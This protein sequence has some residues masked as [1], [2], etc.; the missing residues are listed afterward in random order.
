M[1]TL[2]KN[3]KLDNRQKRIKFTKKVVK[4][5]GVLTKKEKSNFIQAYINRQ[6]FIE[7]FIQ[8][9]EEIRIANINK[10]NETVENGV[11]NIQQLFSDEY[12]NKYVNSLIPIRFNRMPALKQK[13]EGD[14][15]ITTGLLSNKQ[16]KK[17]IV[18]YISPLSVIF[19]NV[20]KKYYERLLE[21]F[22]RAGGNINLTSSA[23][24][25]R[26]TALSNEII[27]NDGY[28]IYLLFKNNVDTLNLSREDSEKMVEIM[29]GFDINTINFNDEVAESIEEPKYEQIEQLQEQDEEEE[30]PEVI[31][32]EIPVINEEDEKEIIENA[33]AIEVLV[34]LPVSE[35]KK[36]ML[37][38][39]TFNLNEYEADKVPTYWLPIFGNE[40]QML[41]LKNRIMSV[42][43]QDDLLKSLSKM[44]WISCDIVERLFPSYFVNLL[45]HEQVK[46]PD[47]KINQRSIVNDD[48]N[49]YMMLCLFLILL[50]IIS[51]KMEGQDYNFI[52]K[53]GKAIQLVLSQIA[54]AEKYV[55]DDIDIL[56][57][58]QNGIAYDRESVIMLGRNL[59]YLLKWFVSF[60]T[61]ST[62]TPLNLSIKDANLTNLTDNVIKL[63]LFKITGPK[64]LIDIGIHDI[65][66]NVLIY[67]EN[68]QDFIF[69]I[70]ELGEN[71]LFKCPKLD[72]IIK[73]KL[74]YFI[75]YLKIYNNYAQNIPVTEPDF[76][77]I[78]DPVR[79]MSMCQYYLQK[80]GKAL[81][82]LFSEKLKDD[83][84]YSKMNEFQKKFQKRTIAQIYLNNMGI[85]SAL[86]KQVLAILEI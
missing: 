49:E 31:S 25:D 72:A 79:G 73:E 56:I 16:K 66:E 58:P 39:K 54:G 4:R 21:S 27:K 86:S 61:I 70:R 42:M 55:S 33:K 44:S 62:I 78:R 85:D 19:D 7:P 84:Q 14:D 1:R 80:F 48:Y 59:A 52:F 30:V 51:N 24:K 6:N 12:L 81:K 82:A 32:Q 43:V 20:P 5:G 29:K 71:A 3:M 41:G 28:G 37:D 67:F 40:Q 47:N 22:V 69:Y 68:P 64:V 15:D 11:N 83:N 65:P 2:K 9:I 76:I 53:G 17:M 57:V 45:V 10:D 50:G 34:P 18:N 35:P 74:F 46:R 60:P 8:N 23:G 26:E 13:Y 75:K 77:N 63:A 38:I 36:P